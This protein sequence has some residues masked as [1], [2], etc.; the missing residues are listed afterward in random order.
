MKP[1][2]LTVIICR[3]LE[4]QANLTQL[5]VGSKRKHNVKEKVIYLYLVVSFF[6]LT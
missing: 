5:E 3:A 1:V 4:G 2:R 6:K